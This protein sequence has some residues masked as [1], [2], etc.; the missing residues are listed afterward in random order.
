VAAGLADLVERAGPEGLKRAGR[1]L[2]WGPWNF[3][4]RVGRMASAGPAA[5]CGGCD[6][7]P[8]AGCL[9]PRAEGS[10]LELV[11]ALCLGRRPFPRGKCPG[12]GDERLE[13]YSAAGFEHLQVQAC[14]AC[15]A[16]L[17]VVDLGQEPEAIPEV[18]ELAG[19]PLDLWAQG[20]GY[21]KLVP[22]LAGV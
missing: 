6:G 12:C 14:E 20:Q 4:G 3:F 7:P 13:Y 2:E 5:A 21:R 17:L 22:N 8:Q 19:L 16:Y 10:A 1:S 9:V 11:C 18:D 15:R